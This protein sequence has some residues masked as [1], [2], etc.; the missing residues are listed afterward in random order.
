[1][2]RIIILMFVF[3][4]FFVMSATLFP[5]PAQS[6]EGMTQTLFDFRSNSGF[7]EWYGNRDIR[8]GFETFDFQS[9]GFGQYCSDGRMLFACNHDPNFRALNLNLDYLKASDYGSKI[10][11]CGSENICTLGPSDNRY[12]EYKV[13]W[14]GTL[15][16]SEGVYYFDTFTMSSGSKLL[17][18]GKV[19]IHVNKF[20]SYGAT[21]INAE[22]KPRDLIF[23]HHSQKLDIDDVVETF[24]INYPTDSKAYIYSSGLVF[25]QAHAELH[26]SVTARQIHMNDNAKIFYTGEY[27]NYELQ[28]EPLQAK[29]NTCSRIPITFKVTN[30]KGEQQ[31]DISGDLTV[32]ATNYID[33]AC[34]ATSEYGAC[35]A[36]PQKT[37]KLLNG[38]K[39]LWLQNKAIG[40]V[41]AE[42]TFNSSDTGELISEEG[43]YTFHAG[44]YRFSPSPLKMVAGKP[45]KL[46]IEAVYGDCDPTPIPDYDGNKKLKFGDVS[47]L[48]PLYMG[49]NAPKKP[50]IN[51]KIGEQTLDI[52]FVDG[53]ANNAVTVRYADSGA[54]SIPV[55]EVS[56][57]KNGDETDALHKSEIIAQ[58]EK[59]R[60][61]AILNVRPYTMAICKISGSQNPDVD[62]GRLSK[63]GEFF[64]ASLKPIIWKS[65]DRN[66]GVVTLDDSYCSRPITQSFKVVDA[67]AAEVMFDSVARIVAPTS[68]TDAIL[69]GFAKT[70][71]TNSNSS[72]LYPFTTLKVSDV[73]TF[74]LQSQLASKYLDMRVNPGQREIGRFYPSH[75]DVASNFTRGVEAAYDDGGNGFTYLGQPFTGEFTI[76]AMDINDKPVKNYHLYQ[77]ATDKA[78]FK[79]WVIDSGGDYP[80]DGPDLSARWDGARLSNTQ[81][82]A[83][84]GGVSEVKV[85]GNMTIRKANTE[86]GPF[87]PLRFAVGVSV[88]DRD[89]TQ[90]ELCGNESDLGC[91]KSVKSPSGG[92]DGAQI[93]EGP[94]FFG[95]MRIGGFTETQDFSGEQTLPVIVEYWNGSHFETNTRD[96]A[97][98]VHLAGSLRDQLVNNSHNIETQIQWQNGTTAEG[99][100]PVVKGVYNFNVVPQQGNTVTPF[101]EQFRFWQCLA[102]GCEVGETPIVGFTEQPWLQY[103]WE[104]ATEQKKTSG[105]VTYGHYRGSDRVIYKGEKS[106]TLTGE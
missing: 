39:K 28:I 89:N 71:N 94:Y 30:D 57:A 85:S 42:A 67:P 95:R 96:N 76:H 88:T 66:D 25:F 15:T 58:S 44:G 83:G 37:V 55:E 69:D 26:G 43:N 41:N 33:T 74:K 5:G 29:T 97:S 50:T 12:Q 101:R 91:S 31:T 99:A 2:I 87:E 64:S 105:L 52:K 13:G 7:V 84:A 21:S 73:G 81:W 10:K 86:D 17:I 103:G 78:A 19:E 59:L 38:S 77:G 54:I 35:S 24:S 82:A 93:A 63:V 45:E 65:G 46:S 104:S 70:N 100:E 75:F 92:A 4:S 72:G 106:I 6:P 3:P 90:F 9:D 80:Y 51:G 62:S 60:G 36:G 61:D 49:G 47:Y 23:Y 18:N 34:W 8:I 20:S 14:K 56:M 68:G 53:R 1:M 40:T 22:G 32:E 16:I 102:S 27:Y 79:D 98:I 11:D 48:Q